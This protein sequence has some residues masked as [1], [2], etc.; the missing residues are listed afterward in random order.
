MSAKFPISVT[1]YLISTDYHTGTNDDGKRMNRKPA[2]KPKS[3]GLQSQQ[4]ADET[5]LLD[6]VKCVKW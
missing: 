6:I 4:Q 3:T 2:P 1:I 5:H